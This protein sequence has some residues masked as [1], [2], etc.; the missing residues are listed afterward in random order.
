MKFYEFTQNNSGGYFDV[1]EN[2]SHRVII[3]A[4]TEEEAEEK[5]RPMI[6]NQSGS[7]ECC[8]ERW[9]V[10]AEEVELERYKTDGYSATFYTHYKDY[11]E[12]WKKLFGMFTR[13][14]KPKII[15]QKWGEEFGTL[16]YLQNIEEYCQF[17]ANRY[18]FNTSPDSIIHYKNG[19]IE[20]IFA[21][22]I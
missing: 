20:K 6:E 10:S 19:K 3:E 13:K 2:V 15:K 18:M 16:V 11:K 8:G 5:F 21:T 12:R 1:D 14:S 22:K 4:E 7:C 9:W 17:M